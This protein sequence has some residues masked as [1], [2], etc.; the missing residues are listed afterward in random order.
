[1]F[2][3]WKN[4]RDPSGALSTERTILTGSGFLESAGQICS[5]K[6]NCG[7]GGR[8]LLLFFLCQRQRLFEGTGNDLPFRYIFGYSRSSYGR[9]TVAPDAVTLRQYIGRYS[10][11]MRIHDAESVRDAV[12]KIHHR[13]RYKGP[14]LRGRI[15]LSCRGEEEPDFRQQ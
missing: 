9:K 4:G 12:E 5:R 6:E 1:M 13:Q 11:D 14:R 15:T 10:S 2:L 3:A 7:D 8:T